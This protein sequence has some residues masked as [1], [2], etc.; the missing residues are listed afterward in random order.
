LRR[1]Q[2][3][4]KLSNKYVLNRDGIYYYVRRIPNDVSDYYPRNR[5]YFSLRTKSHAAACKAAQAVTH[6]L[7]DYWMS[8]RLKALNIPQ[9]P[10]VPD[11]I[12]TAPTLTEAKDHYL[13]LKGDGKNKA[14]FQTA[15][16]AAAY[17]VE[18]LGD[19][20]LSAYTSS[21]AAFFRDWLLERGLSVDSVKRTFATVRPMINLC[22][23]EMG[24]DCTNAFANTFMPE[25]EAKPKREPVP[26]SSIK[27]VQD[28]CR[29]IDDDLRHLIAVISDTGM[30]L[31]E[32]AG[33]KVSDIHFVNAGVK[34]DHCGGAKL[35]HLG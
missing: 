25:R 33:L 23:R 32:A 13:R 6:K 24:L 11:T 34:T 4:T 31:S 1:F 12:E 16:R 19:R 18:A 2:V 22:I 28:E 26:N 20:S 8:L 9:L 14:F 35:D 10:A 7:D 30:R 17:V 27:L 5:L 21:D 3:H 15:E 29:E